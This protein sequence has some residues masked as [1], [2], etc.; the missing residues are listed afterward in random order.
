M[1]VRIQIQPVAA[2]GVL[3]G[4]AG[5]DGVIEACAQIILLGDRVK[6][7]AGE[8]EAI[9]DGVLLSR[10]VAPGSGAL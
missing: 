5:D 4:K 7:L 3:L 9:G 2:V 6:L 8:F 10:D 1:T